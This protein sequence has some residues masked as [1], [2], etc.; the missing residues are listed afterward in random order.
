MKISFSKMSDIKLFIY[1]VTLILTL[2]LNCCK[3]T[4]TDKNS[5]PDKSNTNSSLI[6]LQ[7]HVHDEV[8]LFDN[9]SASGD[10][11]KFEKQVEGDFETGRGRNYRKRYGGVYG[12]YDGGGTYAYAGTYGGGDVGWGGG[13]GGGKKKKGNYPRMALSSQFKAFS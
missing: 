1:V 11:D 9:T 3:C 7:P 6:F 8:Q 5:V 12:G 4:L 2:G 13:G 10:Y